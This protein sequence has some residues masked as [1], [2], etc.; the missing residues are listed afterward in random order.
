MLKLRK[1]VKHF[2]CEKEDEI[3]TKA[4]KRVE[5]KESKERKERKEKKVRNDNKRCEE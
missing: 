1:S 4:E 3:E 2:N 5:R